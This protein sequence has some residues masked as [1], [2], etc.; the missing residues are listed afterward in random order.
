M[1]RKFKNVMRE[2]K[3]RVAGSMFKDPGAISWW[4][5]ESLR[6]ANPESDQRIVMDL[7]NSEGMDAEDVL[8]E[9]ALVAADW[10][11]CSDIEGTMQVFKYIEKTGLID[12]HQLDT[13]IIQR[14]RR[15]M[16]RFD[17]LA[18][19]FWFL[20]ELQKQ[21]PDKMNVLKDLAKHSWFSTSVNL[22]DADDV[23]T[24]NIRAAIEAGF[25]EPKERNL[26]KR[27][28][29]I[30][31]QQ[32]M[33]KAGETAKRRDAIDDMLDN[34]RLMRDISFSAYSYYQL[35]LETM[36]K[37]IDQR[38]RF[39]SVLTDH[40]VSQKKKCSYMSGF[41][42]KYLDGSDKMVAA[43][44]G[45]EATKDFLLDAVDASSRGYNAALSFVLTLVNHYRSITAFRAHPVDEQ[46]MITDFFKD[47]TGLL[48]V[49]AAL[50][51]EAVRTGIAALQ[52][53]SMMVDTSDPAQR[54]A[55]QYQQMPG[56]SRRLTMAEVEE[57]P[58]LC[59]TMLT[60]HN[61]PNRHDARDLYE[62]IL[63]TDAR[64]KIMLIYQ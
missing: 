10:M 26:L 57:M 59:R 11:K 47:P 49:M 17:K 14:G 30:H 60:F 2:I 50:E 56:L 51:P 39:L 54:N 22:D 31:E 35:W 43:L 55:K 5:D 45:W 28:L 48:R 52:V 29:E 33:Q 21:F 23:D 61:K 8:L 27:R 13:F 37:G 64:Q 7:I 20:M 42:M 36:E 6:R 25:F 24:A 32:T 62:E 1:G 16:G 34:A 19:P 18:E 38:L 53:L 41:L 9:I 63:D 40:K 4:L 46:K 58:N 15:F 12:D 44:P 3:V